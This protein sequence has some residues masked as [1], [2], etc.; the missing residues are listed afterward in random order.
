MGT[1]E[2]TIDSDDRLG[3]ILFSRRERPFGR[4]WEDW[5]VDWWQWLLSIPKDKN[6]G[7]DTTGKT[8]IPDSLVADV[9][10]LAGNFGGNSERVAGPG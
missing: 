1:V 3:Q 5:T 7:L 4:S 2:S 9:V 10:F 8:V 6:P